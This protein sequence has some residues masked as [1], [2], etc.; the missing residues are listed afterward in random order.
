M[1]LLFLISNSYLPENQQNI[2]LNLRSIQIGLLLISLVSLGSQ[3]ARLEGHP[4]CNQRHF[5]QSCNLFAF[6]IDGNL[7]LSSIHQLNKYVLLCLMIFGMSSNTTT[8]QIKTRSV[9][10]FPLEGVVH[11]AN[12]Q[13]SKSC[14]IAGLHKIY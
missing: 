9:Q 2:L 7:D 14:Q 11:T 1:S 10:Q 13:I 4:C 12:F 8:L 5:N 3:D 6:S